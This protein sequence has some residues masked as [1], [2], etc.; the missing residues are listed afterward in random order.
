MRPVV[1]FAAF[2]CL[3]NVVHAAN[4]VKVASQTGLAIY[5]DSESVVHNDGKARAWFWYK[6]DVPFTVPGTDPPVSYKEVKALES[7]K[8]AERVYI[9]LVQVLY[10]DQKA[11]Y[12]TKAAD[13]AENYN[14]VVPGTM[15][16]GMFNFTCQRTSKAD[17]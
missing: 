13:E 10:K 7:F 4:W 3:T 8:C 17:N 12:T 5:A 11:F 1:F 14:E 6:Y 2:V 9:N 15:S 16:E